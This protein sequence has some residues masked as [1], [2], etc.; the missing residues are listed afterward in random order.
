[1]MDPGGFAAANDAAVGF[2]QAFEGCIIKPTLKRRSFRFSESGHFLE[3]A[4]SI[5]L[6]VP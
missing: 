2:H 1:M 5:V 3:L 6:S 4:L